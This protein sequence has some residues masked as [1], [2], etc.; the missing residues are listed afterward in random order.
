[1]ADVSD[2]RDVRENVDELNEDNYSDSY[3][4]ALIDSSG[5][6]GASAEIWRKKAASFAALVNTSEA[7][8]SRSLSDLSKNAKTMADMWESRVPNPLDTQDRPIV[9]RIQR[10]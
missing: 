5:V 8:A 1:M 3:I 2:I 7:G 9:R 4:S 10:P 6:A